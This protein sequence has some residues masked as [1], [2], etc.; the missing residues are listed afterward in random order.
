[1]HL[2][3]LLFDY[4]TIAASPGSGTVSKPCGRAAIANGAS[5]ATITVSGVTATSIILAQIETVNVGVCNVV[6]VPGSGSFVATSV[7]G[8]GVATTTTGACTFS[9]IVLN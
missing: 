2:T 1:M 9:W 4:A 3:K 7:N 5:S 8:T 6:C